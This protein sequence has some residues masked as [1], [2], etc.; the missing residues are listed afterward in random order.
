VF[1]FGKIRYEKASTLK[2]TIHRQIVL[3]VSSTETRLCGIYLTPS[4][5]FSLFFFFC[6]NIAFFSP[7][8]NIFSA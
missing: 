4:T 2:L 1:G 5:P 7:G 8:A 3:F 6:C